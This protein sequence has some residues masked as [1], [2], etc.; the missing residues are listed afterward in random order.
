MSD[1]ITLRSQSNASWIR[2]ALWIIIAYE[3]YRITLPHFLNCI[4]LLS[5]SSCLEYRKELGSLS[6]CACLLWGAG[7]GRG[8]AGPTR[9]KRRKWIFFLLLLF[10]LSERSK[11]GFDQIGCQPLESRKS[12]F[13]VSCGWNQDKTAGRLLVVG[14]PFG[15]EREK[16]TERQA[17]RNRTARGFC[18]ENDRCPPSPFPSS[19]PLSL[20]SL[21]KQE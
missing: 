4:V 20:S 21:P 17:Q 2:E 8:G 9:G 7:C 14:H 18:D 15:R 3:W 1:C 16:K 13:A 19:L 12:S 10:I 5:S 11:A 6:I